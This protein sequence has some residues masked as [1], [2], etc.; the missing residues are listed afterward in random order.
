M[1]TEEYRATITPKYIR[2]ALMSAIA[3]G[4]QTH[5]FGVNTKIAILNINEYFS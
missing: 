5:R 3:L 4:F 2:L 1:E